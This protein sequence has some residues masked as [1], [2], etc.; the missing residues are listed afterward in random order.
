VPE[1]VRGQGLLNQPLLNKDT[2]FTEA[3]RE[4]LGL[5]GLLPAAVGLALAMALGWAWVRLLRRPITL[6]RGLGPADAPVVVERGPAAP[7]NMRKNEI[8]ILID[9]ERKQHDTIFPLIGVL[10]GQRI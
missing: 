10:P 3:E 8:P 6:R 9:I 2:A 1:G 4:A 7:L 5:E